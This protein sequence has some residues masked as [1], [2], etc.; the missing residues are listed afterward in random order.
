MKKVSKKVYQSS[1]TSKMYDLF[2]PKG[3]EIQP[4]Q[5]VKKFG[6]EQ[7]NKNKKGVNG[8]ISIDYFEDKNPQREE[9]KSKCVTNGPSAGDTNV[10]LCNERPTMNERGEGYFFCIFFTPLHAVI[11]P[12]KTI[13]TWQ[14]S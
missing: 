5:K 13:S 12:P 14:N 1:F 2:L 8:E 4:H 7:D 3:N 10:N 6:Q 9:K 11:Q